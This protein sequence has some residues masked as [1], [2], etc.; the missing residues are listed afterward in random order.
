M[1]GPFNQRAIY[2]SRSGE[3]LIGGQDGLDIIN[4]LNLGDG[5]TKERPVFSGLLLFDHEVEVGEKIDG[6]VILEKALDMQGE[7]SLAYHQNQF[8]IHMASD[9][10]GVNNST[11]Y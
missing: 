10:G 11:R 4:T 8:T 5:N 3:L 6:G 1:P 7:I 2:C 9:N